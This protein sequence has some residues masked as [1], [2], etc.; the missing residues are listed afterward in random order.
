LQ[1]TSARLI[2]KFIIKALLYSFAYKLF[3]RALGCG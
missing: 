1:V 3:I 2:W